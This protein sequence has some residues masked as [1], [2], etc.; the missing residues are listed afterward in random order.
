LN[1]EI[2]R[3]CITTAVAATLVAACSSTP[4]TTPSAA[5]QAPASAA[6]AAPGTSAPPSAEPTKSDVTL[7]VLSS[8]DWIR[9]PEQ[10]LAKRFEDQTGIHIDYQIVPAA[11][12][13]Q[14][15]NTKLNSGQGPDIFGGQSGKS[16]L[17]VT[18][19]VE[20]NAVD[21][22]DQE[23][24]K[25]EDPAS[26]DQTTLDGKVWGQEIWDYAGNEW[27][28]TYNKDIFA[29]SGVTAMPKTWDE[30]MAA[31]AKIAAAGYTP[32]YEPIS[33]GWH[34]VLWFPE[35]GPR[36]EELEPGLAAK[37]N[38]NQATF[39]GDQ[40]MTTAMTQINDLYQKGYFGPN[41]L[42]DKEADTNAKMAGGTYAMTV[43]QLSRPGNIHADFPDIPEAAFGLLPKPVLDGQLQPVNPAAPTK[44]I[45]S[46]SQHIDEAKRFLAFLAQPDSLQYLVDN[47]PRF[48]GINFSDIKG[49]WTADQQAFLDTYPAKTSVYQTDV[50][51]VNPQWM[52]IG[53]DMTA[54]FTGKSTP[55]DVMKSVDS[56]RQQQATAA[57]DPAW[58]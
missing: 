23:W 55:A 58:K 47:E 15:L 42:S 34:H 51:Y 19:N 6:S 40:N 3:L 20:A 30:F 9:A 5:S 21:L 22:S 48:L 41:A 10:E 36:F 18:L 43:S 33:D 44:F 11:N 53:K 27:V 17:K 56:R 8:Q 12:Y 49:K 32:I 39:A 2:K 46:K 45:W 52:D 1:V 13:F 57:S 50:T 16:D 29:K 14:V 28:L 37:L 26:V 25:R 54:M 4:A 38:A 7:T 31:C 24:V 35:A